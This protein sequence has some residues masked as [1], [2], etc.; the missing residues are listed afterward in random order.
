MSPATV[1]NNRNLILKIVSTFF[2]VGYLPF[3]PGTFASIVGLILFYLIKDN[4]FIY[5]LVT[6]LLII[7]GFFSA[8]RAEKI[9]KI[10]DANCI[11]IDEVLGMLLALMFIPYSIKLIIIAFVL[12]RILDGLKPYPAGPLQDMKGSLGIMSDDIVAG[13][14]TN[15][16]LQLVLRL[17]SVKIS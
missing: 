1:M 8:G 17:A 11:V 3:F 2:Y 16:I 4:I 12:F 10:K 15:I 9:F 7:S 6:L 14:Y 13:L 5:T